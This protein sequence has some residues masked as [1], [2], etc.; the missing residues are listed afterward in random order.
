M[1][2]SNEKLSLLTFAFSRFD[3][4][5]WHLQHLKVL[6]F[7]EEKSCDVMSE[8]AFLFS[9]FYFLCDKKHKK[10]YNKYF[11]WVF[12]FLEAHL[13]TLKAFSMILSTK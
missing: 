5:R 10:D 3:A 8:K 12:V 1:V 7:C 4:Q 13:F 6:H 2:F 9:N 11:Y